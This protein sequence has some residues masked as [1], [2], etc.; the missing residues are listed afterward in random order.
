MVLDLRLTREGC[1]D[2]TLLYI[3]G[4]SLREEKMP[5]FPQPVFLFIW[6]C[7][8]FGLKR[9]KHFFSLKDGMESGWLWILQRKSFRCREWVFRILRDDKRH[10]MIGRLE[11]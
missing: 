4:V 6:G 2:D 7:N 11:E 8:R 3:Y 10:S 1:R 9:E 5:R